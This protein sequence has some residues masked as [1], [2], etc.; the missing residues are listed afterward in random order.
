VAGL[1]SGFCAGDATS[2]DGGTD[3]WSK[4]AD[5]LIGLAE[6]E[7]LRGLHTLNVITDR[8]SDEGLVGGCGCAWQGLGGPGAVTSASIVAD[9]GAGKTAVASIVADVGAGKTAVGVG[10]GVLQARH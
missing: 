3:G 10:C 7:A 9:F 8:T 1:A 4:I 2:Q 6:S 5:K